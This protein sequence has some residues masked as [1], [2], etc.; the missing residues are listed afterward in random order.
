MA[1]K[2]DQDLMSVVRIVLDTIENKNLC[3]VGVLIMD[4]DSSTLARLKQDLNHEIKIV[5]RSILT[6]AFGNITLNYPTF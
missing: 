6:I 4:E 1:V 3:K 5:S 2:L